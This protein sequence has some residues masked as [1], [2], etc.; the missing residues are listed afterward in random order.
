M[1]TFFYTI[2]FLALLASPV[3]CA[4][5]EI[6]SGQEQ[7]ISQGVENAENALGIDSTIDPPIMPTKP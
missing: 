1:K 5:D 4:I 7:A 2:S 6:N 3:S